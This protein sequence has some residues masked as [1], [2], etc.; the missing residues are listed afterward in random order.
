[1]FYLFTYLHIYKQ[2]NKQTNK[3]TYINIYIHTH[4]YTYTLVISTCILYER[5]LQASRVKNINKIIPPH[6]TLLPDTPKELFEYFSN[7]TTP[8]STPSLIKIQELYIQ[9]YIY[10]MHY[11]F[12]KNIYTYKKYM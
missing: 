8:S 2:T 9:L 12:K 1:M 7:A 6:T 5:N 4:I 3:Q 10:G 11:Q